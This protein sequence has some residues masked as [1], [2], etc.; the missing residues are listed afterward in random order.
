MLL[1]KA[2]LKMWGQNAHV[3]MIKQSIEVQCIA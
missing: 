2:P 1:S 3:Y